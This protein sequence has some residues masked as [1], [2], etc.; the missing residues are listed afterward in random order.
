MPLFVLFPLAILALLF[1][2]FW[3]YAVR[4]HNRFVLWLALL[5]IGCAILASHQLDVSPG[6]RFIVGL[7]AYSVVGL[8]V[9]W[10]VRGIVKAWRA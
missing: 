4:R 2:L 9:Y 1:Y 7:W 3:K 8:P 5:L 10:A 6:T